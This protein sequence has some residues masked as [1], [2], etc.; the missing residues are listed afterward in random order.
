MYALYVLYMYYV[1]ANLFT[2][3][4]SYQEGDIRL[5]NGSYNWEGRVEIYLSGVWGTVSDDFQGSNTSIAEVIC[6]QLG[7]SPAG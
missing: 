6:R 4:G 7:H 5:V 2:A 3:D 1:R